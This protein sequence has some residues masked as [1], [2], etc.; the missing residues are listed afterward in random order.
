M[1]NAL[2]T[3]YNVFSLNAQTYSIVI[4]YRARRLQMA[5]ELA[6][7]SNRHIAGSLSQNGIFSNP[8]SLTGKLRASSMI[9][10]NDAGPRW[11]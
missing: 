10:M 3:E 6:L 4:M 11:A 2:A 9:C 7:A 8:H 1:Q 5:T